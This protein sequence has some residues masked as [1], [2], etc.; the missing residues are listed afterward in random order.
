MIDDVLGLLILA[1]VSSIATR[2]MVSAGEVAAISLLAVGFLLGAVLGG[3]AL[4]SQGAGR[5]VNRWIIGW[6]MVPRG[7]VGLIFAF[8]GKSLGVV[9][10]AAF[11]VIVVM[12]M[13]TTLVTPP[14]LAY[15]LRGTRAAPERVPRDATADPAH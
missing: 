9:N 6:G 11:S 10:D 13:L 8:V 1:V 2:G 3:H 12:V 15:L 5:G 4:A 14:M 7:E